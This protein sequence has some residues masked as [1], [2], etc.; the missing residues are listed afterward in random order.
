MRLLPRA[1][2]P[3]LA[4]LSAC[5]DP[6]DTDACATVEE[7]PCAM[8]RREGDAWVIGSWD[9]TRVHYRSL[10]TYAFCH[11]LGREP[12]SVEVYASFT[13]NGALAQQIGN[14]AQV[15]PTCVT[16]EG[17]MRD[18]VTPNVLVLRNAGT[19]DFWA[20]IVIR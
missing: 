10:R 20:R 19:Q 17:A 13:Y 7:V 18:G 3:G 16:R 11:D 1:A 9:L 2:L 8:G 4:A 5:A 15:I 12:V 14:V 6:P